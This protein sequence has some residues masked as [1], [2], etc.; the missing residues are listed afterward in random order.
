MTEEEKEK[1]IIE[2]LAELNPYIN[3]DGGNLEYI[4]YENNYVYIKLSGA[5]QNCGF[6]DNTIDNGIY[7][8][9]REAI[10]DLKGVINS[11]F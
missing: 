4:K 6:I 8:Y 3:M 10:P 5:C 7:E 2:L 1:K 9:L 11:N